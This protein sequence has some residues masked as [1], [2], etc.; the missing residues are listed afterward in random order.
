MPWIIYKGKSAL[1]IEIDANRRA[2]FLSFARAR[3]GSKGLPQRGERRYEWEN[4]LVFALSPEE[5]FDIAL[6]AKDILEGRRESLEIYHR[7]PSDT[8]EVD[9]ILTLQPGEGGN[10]FISLSQGENK[11]TVVLSRGDLFRLSTALPVMV[12]PLLFGSDE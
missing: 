7:P 9:K 8:K 10:A 12:S 1:Q 11:I 4:K 3:E 5:A 6:Q 2:I